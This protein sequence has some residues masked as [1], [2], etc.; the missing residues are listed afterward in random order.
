M[1]GYPPQPRGTYL[2]I[3]DMSGYPPQPRGTYLGI[4]DMFGSPTQPHGTSLYIDDMF[5]YPTQP[6]GIYLG[7]DNMS[8]YPTQPLGTYLG[9]DDMSGYPPQPRG[10]YLG[11]DDM[12]GYPPQPRGTY[13]GIDDMSGY[14]PQPRGTYLGIDDMSGY[15]PQPRGTYLG[16]DDMFGSP[17]QPRVTSS[18][19]AVLLQRPIPIST[20]P[21]HTSGTVSV[22]S[23]PTKP[24]HTSGT[25][26]VSSSPTKPHRTSGTVNVSSSP[27]KPH[28][29]SGTVN[30]S[31]SPTKPHHTSG[32][33][34][35][36]SSPTKPHHTSGTVNV[37][38]STTKPHHMFG[39][40]NLP[41]GTSSGTASMFGSL[42]L[43]RDTCADTSVDTANMF[44]SPTLPR[45]TSLDAAKMFGSKKSFYD[46]R[47][48][49]DEEYAES[50]RSDMDKQR[51]KMLQSLDPEP[52]DGTL[53]KV[54][55]HDKVFT[56][57][58]KINE[59]VQKLVQYVAAEDATGC[60]FTIQ[61]TEITLGYAEHRTLE[62]CGITTRCVFNVIMN[63]A[64]HS[65]RTGTVRGSEDN[66]VT[67]DGVAQL[68]SIHAATMLQQEEPAVHFNITV[69]RKKVLED[70]LR[71][72][73][74]LKTGSK[75]NNKCFSRPLKV[76][77]LGEDGQDYGGPRR[78]YSTLLMHSLRGSSFLQGSPG[79]KSFTHDT[80]SLQRGTFRQLGQ[81]VAMT[82][83]QGGSGPQCLSA[84][85]VNYILN[86]SHDAGTIDDV[87]DPS[88]QEAL[89]KLRD[90]RSTT[91]LR[92]KIDEL[93]PQRF[94]WGIVKFTNEMDIYD[95]PAIVSAAVLHLTV[96][97][98]KAELDQFAEG[99]KTLGVLDLCRQRAGL[100]GQFLLRDQP[101]T[102][103]DSAATLDSLIEIQLSP[104]GSRCRE[105]EE[106]I[107]LNWHYFLMLVEAGDAVCGGQKLSIADV[108]RWI[109]GADRV[110][111]EGFNV[112]PT[113]TF[114]HEPGQRYPDVN[115]CICQVK[116]HASHPEI[117]DSEK[118]TEFFAK[119][120]V[121]S[122]FFGKW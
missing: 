94:D 27:T 16:I 54:K 51:E 78:E 85:A 119:C 8:G 58:F 32:T 97:S 60:P 2:G 77:F 72:L 68:T 49:Q 84:P 67:D 28:R 37:S 113:M 89:R 53:M 107:A 117:T 36:S 79:R 35:V 80:K 12:S 118:S 98:Q 34:N 87:P 101:A 82:S 100:V 70:S 59:S 44:G 105:V 75:K 102:R 61:T 88:V 47:Q 6:R 11:I 91:Q 109:T 93:L 90:I 38:S 74:F 48:Q 26:N 96:L 25:V 92:A 115:T 9:I 31:S 15:P 63:N 56:R 43:P 103:V 71:H 22:S 64:E 121:C 114:A 5:G 52:T 62:E 18:T 112:A 122:D 110:P 40:P 19:N 21:H 83:L 76:Q 46:T 24:H 104:E 17:T 120:I 81:L 99:L 65:T 4:D 116:M 69:R 7:I 95:I 41:C 111:A 66:I 73:T 86:G 33:V 30:V 10:T 55:L 3:D 20:K 42:N 39:S 50:L 108:L 29:T 13:L 1:S 106:E 23:S 57:R 14:P 45:G